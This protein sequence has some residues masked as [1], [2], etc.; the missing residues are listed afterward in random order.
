M[1]IQLPGMDGLEVTRKVKEDPSTAD[2]PVVALT[3]H[4]R[5]VDERRAF[6]A[7]CAG[8]ISKP[9]RLATF[10]SQVEGFIRSEAVPQTAS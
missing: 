10:P 1:D 7:G 8:Y 6:E 9:I 5:E 4:V 3:A 2:V